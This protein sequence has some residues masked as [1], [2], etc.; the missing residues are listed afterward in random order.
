M[1]ACRLHISA[2]ET[3]HDR[4]CFRSKICDEL[5]TRAI[6]CIGYLTCNNVSEGISLIVPSLANIFK[7]ICMHSKSV[8]TQKHKFVSLLIMNSM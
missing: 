5:I 1:Y 2:A 4:H 7:E 8:C 6:S 3:E